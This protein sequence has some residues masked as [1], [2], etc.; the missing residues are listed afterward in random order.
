[1]VVGFEGAITLCGPS[2]LKPTKVIESFL[3][4]M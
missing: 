2:K 1:M 4:Y 3:V